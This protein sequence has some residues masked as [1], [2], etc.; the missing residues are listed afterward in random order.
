MKKESSQFDIARLLL[1]LTLG[2]TILFY[3]SQ[4]MLGLFGGRGFSATVEGMSQG[5]FP[6]ALVM[7]AIAAE[8][9]GGLGL[10][11]GLLTPVAAFGVLS[12]MAVAS[13][14]VLNRPGTIEKL[15][16]SGVPADAHAVFFPITLALLALA[17]LMLGPGRYSLDNRL[18]RG[19]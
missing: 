13:V 4:K 18:F 12:T 5:G 17:I 6:P 10:V 7:L 9:F 2:L 8:F 14:T 19:R 16:T 15:T 1:R 11:V 3:G